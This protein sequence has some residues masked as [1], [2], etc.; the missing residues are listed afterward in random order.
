[1]AGQTVAYLRVSTAEQNIDR[2][3]AAAEGAD[4][5]FE[6][7]ISGKNTARPLLQEMIAY[8]REGDTVRVHSIDRLARSL[9]DLGALMDQFMKKGVTVMFL[10]ENLTFNAS[11]TDPI[12]KFQLHIMGAF[13]EFER[14]II[15]SRQAE[16]IAKAKERGVY[17]KRSE[18]I[19]N[20]TWLQ[21]KWEL[22]AGKPLAAVA[23]VYGFKRA[24]VYRYRDMVDTEVS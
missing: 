22:D 5:V 17:A 24:T 3:A 8:V 2:Q 19:P 18:T 6:E 4:K 7:K 9:T 11:S 20:S 15:R 12:A 13:A 14:E 23:K 21:M 1:M 16:G 10:K